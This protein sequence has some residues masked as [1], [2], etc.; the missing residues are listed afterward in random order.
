VVGCPQCGS[1]LP[2]DAKFCAVCG[3][4]I[5]PE[6]QSEAAAVEPPPELLEAL[7][8]PAQERWEE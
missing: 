3:K 4:A 6:Q 8:T 7:P 5:T 2:A 1:A